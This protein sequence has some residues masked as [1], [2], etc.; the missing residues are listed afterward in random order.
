MA[1]KKPAKPMAGQSNDPSKKLPGKATMF[2]GSSLSAPFICPTCNRSLTKG[3]VYEELNAM[4][5]TR[6]CIPK[7]EA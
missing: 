7:V 3:I 5:C 2:F 4:Y 1:G 6:G